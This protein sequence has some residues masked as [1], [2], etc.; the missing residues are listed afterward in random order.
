MNIFPQIKTNKR[1]T[2]I[3]PSIRVAVSYK[4]IREVYPSMCVCVSAEQ[5]PG[6]QQGS[7][8]RPQVNGGP[9]HQHH[10]LQDEG[11]ETK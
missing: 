5:L 10:L 4:R 9:S 1:N 7:S 8:P 6:Q 3:R 2:A 11:M